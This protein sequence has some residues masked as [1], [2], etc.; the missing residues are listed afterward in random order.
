MTKG[1]FVGDFIPSLLQTRDVEVAIKHYQKGE[2]EEV[3]YHKIAT[4]ITAVVSGMV[5]MNDIEYEAG[6]IITI[7]PYES[8]DF[9]ALK[10]NTIT[11]VVKHPGAVC[12]KY[13]GKSTRN[14]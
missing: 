8:T 2:A 4:E 13:M 12:D 14:D 11:V 9:M 10:D 6:D 1:W 3:H 7:E 5:K